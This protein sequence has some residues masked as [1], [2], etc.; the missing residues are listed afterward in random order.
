MVVDF[1]DFFRTATPKTYVVSCSRK[2]ERSE[3]RG[4]FWDFLTGRE[5][6]GWLHR[7]TEREK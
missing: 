6:W 3:V 5:D 1:A 2:E 4:D 7:K